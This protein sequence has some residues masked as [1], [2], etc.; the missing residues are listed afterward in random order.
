MSLSAAIHTAPRVGSGLTISDLFAGFGGSVTGAAEAGFEP[1]LLV[2]HNAL[3]VRVLSTNFPNATTACADISRTAPSRFRATDV[4]WASPSCTRHSLAAG[5]LRKRQAK[6]EADLF[7]Q[8]DMAPDDL[9]GGEASRALMLD[10]PRWAEHFRYRC[11]CV[12]N[13]V[14]VVRSW[15]L[16][17]AWRMMMEALGYNVRELSLS[18]RIVGSPQDRDRL[19]IVCWLKGHPAPDL[20]IRP[21]APC[22]RCAA[23]VQSVQVFK[24]SSIR[25][26]RRT[27][28]PVVGKYRHGYNYHCPS[29]AQIVEPYYVGVGSVLDLSAPAPV[30]GEERHVTSS[31]SDTIRLRL[32]KAFADFGVGPMFLTNNC[33]THAGRARPLN[34]TGF[35]LTTSNTHGI[36]I[37]DASAV[38]RLADR[39]T[40][41]L[42]G[43]CL[44]SVADFER[45]GAGGARPATQD[46]PWTT[47]RDGAGLSLDQVRYRS[48]T[49][50]E[51]AAMMSFR[52]DYQLLGTPEEQ[53]KGI[54]NAVDPRMARLL[55]SRVAATFEA[56]ARTAVAA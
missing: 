8:T 4:L 48:L 41:P 51:R 26:A 35:T 22:A 42:A 52:P 39:S 20:D 54:G 38:A 44:S 24:E 19:F 21:L 13:V 11:I 28:R 2:N 25:Q 16:Y 5:A 46:A 15:E 27:G 9:D 56:G 43:S 36:A 31:T 17:P 34:D 55:L 49:I 45:L 50:A 33:T 7:T 10:V 3:A 30:L 14:D 29:C 53:H 12:E 47:Y 1:R 6:R 23:D 40:R 32:R 37:P 18:S